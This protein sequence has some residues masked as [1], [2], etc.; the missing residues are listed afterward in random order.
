MSIVQRRL[1]LKWHKSYTAGDL[2]EIST[3]LAYLVEGIGWL[4]VGEARVGGK[5]FNMH[6]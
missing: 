6:E 2:G 5:E 4:A 3:L 1:G